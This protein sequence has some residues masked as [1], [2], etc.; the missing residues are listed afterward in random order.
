M[1]G[2]LN[3]RDRGCRFPG[4][5][6]TRFLDAHHIKHWANG[7]ETKPSNLIPLCRFHHRK[8]HEGAVEVHVLDDGAVRFTYPNG[9]FVDGVA[10]EHVHPFTWKAL[11]EQNAAQGIHIDARI[12]ARTAVTRWAGESMDYRLPV[13]VLFQQEKRPRKIP[14]GTSELREEQK[15]A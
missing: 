9:R 1:R 13:E 2:F 8:V 4:C 15:R 12:D 11:I 3:A 14:A 7:G 6:N 5:A 10:P